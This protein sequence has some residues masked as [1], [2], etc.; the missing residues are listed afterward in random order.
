MRILFVNRMASMERGGGETFDLEISKR[1]QPMGCEISF[2]SGIPVFGRARLPITHATSHVLRTPHTGRFPWDKVKAGWR[3]RLADFWLFEHRAAAWALRRQDDF[4]IVQVCELPFFVDAWKRKDGR[5]PVVMR[6]TAPNYW[7]GLGAVAKADAVIASGVTYERVKAD[8]RADCV[9]VSN[10]VDTDLFRPHES[11]FRAT[12]GIGSD[13]LVALYVARFQ[14]FKNHA[15]LVEAFRLF[16]RE[17]PKGRLVLV[18]SGPLE[19]RVKAQCHQL[20]LDDKVLFLGEVPFEQL[21]DIYAA[22]DIKAISSE[23][24]SFCFAALEAM[25]TE[26]PI[27][28]TDC[29]WVPELIRGECGGRVV[30]QSEPAALGRALLELAGQPERRRE[31]GR[32]NRRHVADTYSW[33]HSAQSLSALYQG[34]VTAGRQTEGGRP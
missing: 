21:P 13:E 28:T 34:L 19:K 9:E 31:M 4:D 12:H 17:W 26:L 32:F 11:P 25:A 7:D 14:D 10:A 18:G 6:L 30:P 33:E 23:F 2:L 5:L 27:V 3:L 1:L 8:A 20:G 15:L 24:E 29:G 22:A 16:V